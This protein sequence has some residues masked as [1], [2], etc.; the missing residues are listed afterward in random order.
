MKS[1]L[2]LIFIIGFV[3]QPIIKAQE[4]KDNQ[5]IIKFDPARDPAKD[6]KVAIKEAK[7][8]N[9]RI[10]LD[11]GGEWCIWCHRVDSFFVAN[12]DVNDFLHNNYIV[13]KVNYS[14]ENKNEK[15]LS[16]YPKVTGYPHFFI[17]DKKGKLLH[18]Q[19]TGEL[20]EGKGYSIEKMKN[21]LKQWAPK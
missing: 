1:L 7:K 15:F 20:E 10:L 21:F 14:K 11:V 9:K 8:S 4:N 13:V 3:S 19:N 18:S 16:A 2:L 17:L 6:L 5:S 12:K